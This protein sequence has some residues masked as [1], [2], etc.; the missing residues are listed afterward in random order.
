MD[1]CV[2]KLAVSHLGELLSKIRA[3]IQ[4]VISCVIKPGGNLAKRLE[5][6]M[7]LALFIFVDDRINATCIPECIYWH[8]GR[9]SATIT[10]HPAGLHFFRHWLVLGKQ[11]NH[12][13][14]EGRDIIR[15]AAADPVPVPDHFRI[16]PVS[17]GVAN[18][19]LEG[20]VA[21]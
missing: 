1:H 5:I 12:S 10:L 19:I 9:F 15:V 7:Q 2:W 18:V 20:I 13:F 21:G 8:T 14:I 4:Y 17:T 16:Q 3:R 6:V 11:A